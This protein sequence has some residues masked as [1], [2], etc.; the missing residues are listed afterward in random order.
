MRLG[1]HRC[2][3]FH[4][5]DDQREVLSA[6]IRD[7]LTGGQKVVYVAD[8]DSSGRVRAWLNDRS[9]S[10]DTF[11][12]TGQ[13]V[14]STAE[15]TYYPG[16]RFD[17]DLTIEM[18]LKSA[19]SAVAG[20]YRGIRL[21]S[22]M[23]WALRGVPGTERVLEFEA[24]LQRLVDTRAATVLCQY[25]LRRFTLEELVDI[26]HVHHGLV[27]PDP[28]YHDGLLRITRTLEP[29]GLAF[30]GD[31]DASNA[32]QVA[33]SVSTALARGGDVRLDLSRL[34][35]CDIGGLRAIVAAAA[36]LDGGRRLVL[37]GTP[38]HLL[39]VMRV[40]GWDEITGLVMST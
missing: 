5:D 8:E 38:P 36:A 4:S 26:E 2:L 9:L 22:E 24:G 17:S 14:F 16:G 34:E 6:F 35:F 29:P 12:A 27:G 23:A 3:G 13:L 40:V 30:A 7:G 33:W 39:Q 32:D 25:D 18:L 11:L 31:I 28:V 15:Q 19:D 37:H 21:A 20:G 1:D 10:P